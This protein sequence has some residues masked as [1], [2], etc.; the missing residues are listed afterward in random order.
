MIKLAAIHLKKTII[1]LLQF[2]TSLYLGV[3][4]LYFY[5]S[6]ARD[7][8]SSFVAVQ[9]EESTMKCFRNCFCWPCSKPLQLGVPGSKASACPFTFLTIPG[10]PEHCMSSHMK[11][12]LAFVLQ[13]RDEIAATDICFGLK[14]E[15]VSIWLY[16]LS[17]VTGRFSEGFPGFCFKTNLYFFKF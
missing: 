13:R 3:L 8:K 12:C 7:C 6:V 16:E 5:Q 17:L 10:D 2:F 15:R 9:E 4:F 11:A 14:E 1:A